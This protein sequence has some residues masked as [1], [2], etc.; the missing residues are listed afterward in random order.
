[1]GG[2]WTNS[3]NNTYIHGNVIMELSVSISQA[4]MSV[5]LQK[6]RTRR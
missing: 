3:G 1:M 6:W 5:F 4:K 2:G